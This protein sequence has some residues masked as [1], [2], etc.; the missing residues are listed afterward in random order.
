MPTTKRKIT[1]Q[2][3]RLY[4]RYI[5]RENLKP[6][7]YEQEIMLLVEQ[8]INKILSAKTMQAQKIRKDEIPQSSIIK[9]TLTVSSNSIELPAFPLDLERDM[10]VWDIVDP[11]NPLTSFVPLTFQT[12]KVM[13]GT[14]VDNL[15]GQV[16][17]YRY[18]KTVNFLS[19]VSHRS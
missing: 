11:A 18:G 4:S 3:R 8:A 9:Y 12:A 7:V 13:Q 17:Y 10:G 19:N 1:E 5:D 15:E 6:T 14:I 2:V 16:G